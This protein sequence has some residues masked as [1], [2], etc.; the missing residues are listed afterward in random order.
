MKEFIKQWLPKDYIRYRLTGCIATDPTDASGTLLFD[1]EKRDWS[2]KIIKVLDLNKEILPIVLETSEFTG[3]TTD[4]CAEE[5]GLHPRT[6]VITGGA[7]QIMASIGNGAI[8]PGVAAIVLGTGG[9]L[10][11]TTNRFKIDNKRRIHTFCHAEKNSWLVMGATLAGGL[12]LRCIKKFWI[13]RGIM[14]SV[15]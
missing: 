3:K 6:D 11:T 8:E 12:S 9:Q 7:D 14:L 13:Y 4:D 2:S 15:L 10:I 1:L 5:T